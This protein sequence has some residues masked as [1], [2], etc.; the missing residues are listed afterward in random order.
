MVAGIKIN[1]FCFVHIDNIQFM[2]IP[3]YSNIIQ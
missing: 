3:G 2:V 1:V